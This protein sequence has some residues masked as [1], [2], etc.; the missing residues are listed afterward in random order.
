MSSS[1]S[2]DTHI[3][4]QPPREAVLDE[5]Q[6]RRIFELSPDML[7]LGNH[8]GWFVEINQAWERTLGYSREEILSRPF[9]EL[10]HP[11]DRE[12]TM[13]E[14]ARLTAGGPPAVGFTNRYRCRDGR[15]CWLSWAAVLETN[16]GYLLSTARDVTAEREAQAELERSERRYRELYETMPDGCGAV[17]AE[18]R[19]TDCNPAFERMIGYTREELRSLLY[20]ELTPARWHEMEERIVRERIMVDGCSGRYEKEYRRRD[21]SVFPVELTAHLIRDDQGRPAGMWA[22]ARDLTRQRE[23]ERELR[24]REAHLQG[25]L[26]T[27][28]VGIG[29]GH[30]RILREVNKRL[31][32]ITGYTPEELLGQSARMLYSS[33]AEYDMVGEK[34]YAEVVKHGTGS[35]ETRW[36]RKDGREMDILLS[37]TPLNLDDPDAEMVFTALDITQRKHAQRELQRLNAEL[38]QRVAER[39]K[40]LEHSNAELEAFSY[41]VSHDLRSPLRLIDGYARMLAEDHQVSLNEEAQ[42]ILDAIRS[43]TRRMNCLI[44]GLLLLSHITRRP[45]KTSTVDCSKLVA[46]V[47]QELVTQPDVQDAKLEAADLPP[48]RADAQLLRQVWANLLS[49]A[50]KYSATRRPARIVVSS[51]CSDGRTWY[52]VRDNGVGFDAAFVDKLFTVFGRLHT[53]DEFPGSGVGLAIVHRIVARHGGSVRAE[54]EIDKGALFQFTLDS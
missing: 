45:L 43:G 47:W 44:D 15:Y 42:R 49:N 32:E 53:E 38:E 26:R 35:V 37:A 52:Q 40:E 5:K 17:D 4:D 30:Q 12:S 39:T 41:S 3:A 25:L 22:I 9:V 21:G 48:A 24:E 2:T 23:A 33:Q 10:L 6:L 19:F 7:C 1:D 36:R 28:P 27:A 18:G 8:D 31:C 51:C 20:Q 54:G 50:L 29:V 16:T 34:G 13:R 11:D 14:V 46:E